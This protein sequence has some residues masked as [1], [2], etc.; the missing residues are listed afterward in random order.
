MAAVKIL[1]FDILA[2]ANE[3]Y[4]SKGLL[5]HEVGVD[6]A[7]RAAKELKDNNIVKEITAQGK[8]KRLLPRWLKADVE[9]TG[10]VWL[11][12][13]KYDQ[14]FKD[15]VMGFLCAQLTLQA[16]TRDELAEAVLNSAEFAKRGLVK[17][18]VLTLVRLLEMERSIRR[19]GNS[20]H[21]M[22]LARG[23]RRIA[24]ADGEVSSPHSLLKHVDP[25]CV[26]CPKRSRCF[27]EGG[28]NLSN[29]EKCSYLHKWL[30]EDW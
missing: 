1:L 21:F 17:S 2:C 27:A 19:M 14:A 23:T 25:P 5:H 12:G 29:P 9:A 26:T 6:N 15:R 11:V 28:G 16:C 3:G 18:H 7:K 13:D 4:P 30:R 8:E 24:V 10:T 20:T 22:L